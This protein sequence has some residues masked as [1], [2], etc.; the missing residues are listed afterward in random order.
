MPRHAMPAGSLLNSGIIVQNTRQRHTRLHGE[1][2]LPQPTNLQAALVLPFSLAPIATG[3][4]RS[5]EAGQRVRGKRSLIGI[6]IVGLLAF[7]IGQGLHANSAR[8]RTI[9][10][11]NIHTKE[12]L[13]VQYKKA[14]KLLPEAMQRINWIMRDWRKDE[15]TEMDPALIDLLWEIHAELGSKEPIHL[16]SAFRSR[17][18]NDMLRRTVGGQAGESRH[19][20]GKAADVHFPDIPLR[21]LRYSALIRERGGVGYYPTS[22]TPFVHIDTD[23][24]RHWPRLPRYE[25]ALLFPNGATRHQP[26]EGGPITREDVQVA[27]ASQKDLVTQVAEFFHIRG[28]PAASPKGFAMASAGSS[29]GPPTPVAKATPAAAV[30]KLLAEPHRANRPAAGFVQPGAGERVALAGLAAMAQVPQLVS[31]P[32]PAERRRASVTDEGSV[33]LAAYTPERVT[34]GAAGITSGWSNGWAPAPAFDEE[35]PEELSYRPFPVVPLLTQSASPDDPVLAVMVHPENARTLD[36]IDQTAIVPL[37]LRPGAVVA[38]QLWAQEFRGD[39]I[40]AAALFRSV[41]ERDAVMASPL[42]NRNVRT[43]AW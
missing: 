4:N 21:Q 22:A 3:T 7:A 20:L 19:I 10:L 14:G 25:L 31:E 43:A 2:A 18:T 24:V 26:A 38:R 1:V 35:H 36:F 32:R 27:R 23:A 16:I 11:H 9:S 42:G 8:D 12:T 28:R 41:T 17:G 30:P 40:N 13:S 37:R 39:A 5:I 29:I 34:G 33:Q 15:A 6:A